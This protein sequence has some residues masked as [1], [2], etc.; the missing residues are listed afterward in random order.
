M[1]S[2]LERVRELWGDE[3]DGYVYFNNDS[4][5]C[6]VRDA[7]S[8]MQLAAARGVKVSRGQLANDLVR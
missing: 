7:Q 5:A 6:A 8:L 4:H 2:W 3:P 1:A